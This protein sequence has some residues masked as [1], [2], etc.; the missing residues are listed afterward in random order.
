MKYQVKI[1]FQGHV[2]WVEVDGNNAAQAKELVRQ[3][4]G[5]KIDVIYCK[6]ADK[7]D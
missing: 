2:S 7:K 4:Y 5:P 1:R 3:Q 6:L